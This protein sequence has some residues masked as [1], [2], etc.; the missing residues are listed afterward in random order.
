MKARLS[1][2]SSQSSIPTLPRQQLNAPSPLLKT[3]LLPLIR[4]KPG[5]K[6]FAHALPSQRPIEQPQ[7]LSRYLLYRTIGTGSFA[8]VKLAMDKVT[9]EVVV[10]KI[11]SK[12][13]VL[14]RRQ[15]AHVMEEKK[16]LERLRHP[17]LVGYKEGFQ[18]QYFLYLVLEYVQGGELYSV[19]AKTGFIEP[20]DAKV[21]ACEVVCA[22]SYLHSRRL[23]YRDIKPENILLTSSGHIKITDFGF[24]KEVTEKT[25]TLCGTPEYLAPEIINREGHNGQ[26][27]WWA[28]GVLLFEMLAGRPP[29]QAPSPFDLY[30]KILTTEVEYPHILPYDVRS[31]IERLLV[32]DQHKRAGEEEIKAAVY[33]AGV[34]W[35]QVEQGS[36]RPHYRPRVKNPF[37][38]S[39]FEKYPEGN[40]PMDELRTTDAVLFANF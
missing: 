8:R 39:H 29:F 34:N 26:C 30:E 21:Y 6:S 12:G 22:I 35:D 18:D 3:G 1:Y 27:D 32:K 24:L 19:L 17:F 33:F 40:L 25:Y 13:L 2:S 16:Q 36:L 4:V 31:L 14:K 20:H 38:A 37:D 9:S 28:L 11:I 7:G 15:L 10:V 23:A 5:R